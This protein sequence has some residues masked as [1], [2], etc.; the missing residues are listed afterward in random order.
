[1]AE[2]RPSHIQ[3]QSQQKG[4]APTVLRR[5]IRA[6]AG[7]QLLHRHWACEVGHAQSFRSGFRKGG[8]PERC[9]FRFFSFF[10]SVFFRFLP[11][12]S[13]FFLV[14]FPFFPFSSVSFRFFPFFSVFSVFAVFSGSVFF[15]F[16][17]FRFFPLLA[18]CCR[19]LPFFSVFFRFFPFHFQKKKKGRHRSRDPSCETPIRVACLQ[20]ETAPEQ[21]KNN[22]KKS[23]LSIVSGSC[24]FAFYLSRQ[25]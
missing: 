24:F 5:S 8:S 18:V 7:Q 10:F 22:T 20:N 6:S 14:F 11:F 15:F 25:K 23:S 9:R 17:F 16:R 3:L 1:M 12:F 2:R 4:C 19:F 21:Q 13:V